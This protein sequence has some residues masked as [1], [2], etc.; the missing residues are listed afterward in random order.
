MASHGPQVLHSPDEDRTDVDLE[1]G[2]VVSSIWLA[3]AVKD[4][5]QIRRHDAMDVHDA[6]RSFGAT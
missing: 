6:K 1:R 2:M 5:T 3:L 4:E